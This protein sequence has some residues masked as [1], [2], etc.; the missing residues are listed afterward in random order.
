MTPS[1]KL[2]RNQLQKHYQKYIDDMY[3]KAKKG[4]W[5][6]CT[7]GTS[8]FDSYTSWANFAGHIAIRK[9]S[10]R[11]LLHCQTWHLQITECMTP[12][13]V[14][15]SLAKCDRERLHHADQTFEGSDRAF[16]PYRDFGK[17]IARPVVL[18][19][20]MSQ[21]HVT[22]SINAYT[23]CQ[24]ISTLHASPGMLP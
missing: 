6:C 3:A 21:L 13:Y 15:L 8:T 5:R 7:K 10:D 14:P 11:S 1:F 18:Q 4:N 17:L 22:C 20:P 23:I 9:G 19:H 16:T 2:K 12:E 24:E